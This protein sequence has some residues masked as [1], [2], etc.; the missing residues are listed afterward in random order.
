MSYRGLDRA[1]V[2]VLLAL[3]AAV[4]PNL[5]LAQAP[6]PDEQ[7]VQLL[8]AARRAYN[9]RNLPFAADKFRQFLQQFANHKDAHHARLGLGLAILESPQPQPQFAIDQLRP[10][11]D[12]AEFAERGLA[13]FYLGTAYRALGHAALLL[14]A[15]QPA[16]APTHMNTANQ[17]F[18]LAL[19]AFEIAASSFAARLKP[20]Y[21]A[22]EPLPADYEWA[23]RARLD[24]IEMLLRLA[25]TKDAM[26]AVDK[27]LVDA[28]LKRSKYLKLTQ[29]YQG[30]GQ[31]ASGEWLT[32]AKTLSQL[33]PFDDP[34]YGT[35][36]RYMLGRS[37]HLLGDAVAAGQHY[38]EILAA[39]D[40]ELAQAKLVAGNAELLKNEPAE[41]ARMLL[42]A[43][44]PPPEYVARSWF[45]SGVMA[46]EQEK[47]ADALE[48]FTKF[49]EQF[50][51]SPLIN[52]AVLRK[53]MAQVRLKQHQEA[54]GTL[55]PI[56]DDAA[57]TD[58]ARWWIG[59]AYVGLANANPPE[60]APG[61]L[62]NATAQLRAASDRAQQKAAQDP[63]AKLRRQ[64]ILLELGDAYQ[65]NK[66]FPEAVATFQLVLNEQPEVERAELGLQR[67]AT[68]L[69]LAAKYPESDQACDQFIKTYPNSTLLSAVLFRR[70]ENSLALAEVAFNTPNLPNRDAA[71]K[72]AYTEVAVRASK[73]IEA[74]PEATE[75][76]FALHA[77]G[78]AQYRQ[79]DI[80]AAAK[81]LSQIPAPDQSGELASVSYLLGDCLLRLAPETAEDA[82]AAGQL[83][84]QVGE[85]AKLLESYVAAN[86]MSPSL[87]DALVKLGDAQLRMALVIDVEQ[88]RNQALQ[89]ARQ[90]Y[91]KVIGQ[92]AQ[93]PAAAIAVYER[94]RCMV[95]QKDPGGAMNEYRR[96]LA[97]PLKNSPVAP[98]AVLRVATMLR[99]DK[100]PQDA[101]EPLNQTRQQHEAALM[102][103]P[104]RAA[105]APLLQYHHALCLKEAN[106]LPEAQALFENLSQ[107]FPKSPEALDAAW[108]VQQCR[109]EILLA[110]LEPARVTLARIDAP[111]PEVQAA[112]AIVQESIT[113]LGQI[114]ALLEQQ[115]AALDKTDKGS[116]SHL[117]SLHEAAWCH[118][119]LAQHEIDVAREKLRADDLAARQAELDKSAP[120]G[121]PPAKAAMP[122]VPLTAIPLQPSEKKARELYTAMIDK[123]ADARLAPVAK[124]QLAEVHAYREEFDKASELLQDALGGEVPEDL[125]DRLHIRLA[126]CLVALGDGDSA[127]GEVEPISKNDKHPLW[128][129]AKF[130]TG[131]ALIAQKKYEPAVEQLKMFRDHGPLQNVSGVSDRA[132]MRLA[133]AYEQINQFEPARQAYEQHWNRFA[134]S[135]WR[136]EARYGMAWCWQK[137][138]QWDAAVNTYTEV[139]K[140]T[141][142]EVA[143]R[144]QYNIGICRFAQQRWQEAADAY[145]LC[146]YTYDYPELASQ[147]LVEAAAALESLKKV[148]E[149]A[150]L[151]TQVGKDYPK[152]KAAVVAAERLQKLPVSQ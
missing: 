26:T 29:Y 112:K 11:A 113:Q 63:A 78:L 91:D 122:D 129:E 34:A 103:D 90:S 62:N 15:Q 147:G 140:L 70:A 53:G 81:T 52:E 80:E 116:E 100:K 77:L 139:T 104:A 47:F 143:A 51:L 114:A 40:K 61:H 94:A 87:P 120:A 135:P 89:L 21:P 32:A 42:I 95:A 10:A 141:T 6:T 50:K 105:W 121:R 99:I 36:A 14:A 92:F 124:L 25:K 45:Y 9:D 65:Q 5:S 123:G 125:A 128:A 152:S 96:F 69:H 84:G 59:R 127:Y 56:Q 7:A 98:M 136:V 79:G 8:D 48:R 148:P 73:L 115:A 66:Q 23:T 117:S 82:L 12:A 72:Q 146:A 46:Y 55:T 149:A 97:D 71:L 4:F 20:P 132:M 35:H 118:R 43:Q 142:A 138:S 30:Y 111:P 13:S 54:V 134:Q 16:Q 41:R 1:G 102:A 137:Q 101:V 107:R 27:L 58:Q 151:L 75:I 76:N 49:A 33:A 145:Q 57:L 64:D 133:Y 109:R 88:E 85:A 22:E 74:Y 60:A 19:K 83:L 2:F 3:W 108:R 44:S 37:H 119:L 28:A 67:L 93:H 18:D 86:P 24:Q 131:E 39:Y 144:A 150:Q 106:K 17:Q 31:Y 68:A 130:L 38:E 126:A 110:K